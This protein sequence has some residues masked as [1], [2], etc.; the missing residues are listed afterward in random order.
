MRSELIRKK[1]ILERVGEM[2][3]AR[4]LME[5]AAGT[6][7]F[8]LDAGDSRKP[9]IGEPLIFVNSRQSVT[10]SQFIGGEPDDV[11]PSD[12]STD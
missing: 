10:L 6:P 5:N 12:T 9:T 4:P 11:V 1:A 7:R 2:R 3:R 8:H